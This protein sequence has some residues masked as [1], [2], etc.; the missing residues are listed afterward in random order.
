MLLSLW[1]GL[2]ILAIRYLK[3][4]DT[5]WHFYLY[6]THYTGCISRYRCPTLCYIRR[7]KFGGIENYTLSLPPKKVRSQQRAM[8]A[9][10]L[11][12]AMDDIFRW[13]VNFSEQSFVRKVTVANFATIAECYIISA[14]TVA[15]WSA[16]DIT[17]SPR[18]GWLYMSR[19]RKVGPDAQHPEVC[20]WIS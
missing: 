2:G 7:K 19:P 13:I 16:A 4:S 5:V 14:V 17:R 15:P 1:A 8:T 18:V 10:A 11:F 9:H 6:S 12:L 3:M 20:A